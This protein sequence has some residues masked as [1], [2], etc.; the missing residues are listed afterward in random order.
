MTA[1]TTTPNEAARYRYG[2]VLQHDTPDHLELEWLPTSS[3]M[4]DEDWKTGLMLLA[5]EAEA[6]GAASI[7]IDA[8]EFR[9]GFEDRDGSMAWRD[10]HVIPRYN[11]AGVTRFAFVMPAGFPGPTAESGAEARVDGSAAAF[12]T[13]WFL[14]RDAA[15]A[16][17][18]EAR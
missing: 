4:S 13:Q 5:T 8:T 12:P 17:L 10:D 16:W 6:T 11:R 14:G 2:V 18:A 1:E 7:L 9:H 3:S 15:L